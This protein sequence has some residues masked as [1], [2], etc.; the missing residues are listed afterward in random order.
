MQSNI[1]PTTPR[2]VAEWMVAQLEA[3]DELP[4][5][6]AAFGIQDRFGA[7]FVCRDA[8]GDLGIARKVLYQFR[9]LTSNTVVWVAVQGNWLEG[10]WRKRE[11]TDVDGRRQWFY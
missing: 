6:A 9:K 2:Q 5:Q 3:A 1:E 10:Y 7:E 8:F 11:R 4:Q